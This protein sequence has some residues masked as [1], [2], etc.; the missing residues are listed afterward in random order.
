MDSTKLFDVSMD[1]TS[2]QIAAL[3]AKF[4]GR[5]PDAEM[6]AVLRALISFDNKPIS[7]VSPNEARKQKTPADAVKQLLEERRENTDPEEVGKVENRSIPGPDG[8]IDIR[9]YTP[10]VARVEGQALP[11]VLYIH[12]GGWVIADLDVYDASARAMCNI[13]HAIVVSTHYRQAPE[14]KF[15][16][17][18]DDTY[19]A[20]KWVL[21]NA[22]DF[23][24]D[25]KRVAIMGESAGG[26]M[27]GVICLRAREDGLQMPLHQVLVYP[28]ADNDMTN[29]SYGEMENAV[30][31]NVAAMKWFSKQYLE[32][33]DGGM[34]PLMW[35]NKANLVGLPPA[36]I[37]NAELDPLRTEGEMLAV[38][39]RAAGVPA[40]QRTYPGVTHEF[41]G[42]SPVLHQ[43]REAQS[44]AGRALREALG[45]GI[46]EG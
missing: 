3:A 37:I 46:G 12:G 40:T 44:L 14:H 38:K 15:P 20:Y 29:E 6:A 28:V 30:P 31:L 19:A 21:A 23:D 27:A 11:V 36:T 22:S 2:E 5:A 18:H 41:F 13:A 32:G 39:M 10:T 16:A 26:N 35:L 17:A 43:A 33:T 9:I 24:G 7:E 4:G 42:M 8:D 34:H 1:G 25:P 45:T